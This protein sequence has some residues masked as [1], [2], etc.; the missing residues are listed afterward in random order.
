MGEPTHDT[1]ASLGSQSWDDDLVMR[2]D[3]V[4][5][6]YRAHQAPARDLRS[7]LTKPWTARQ[8]VTVDAVCGVS[9]DLLR[10]EALGIIGSNGSGK[11]TLLRTLAGLHTPQRGAVWG[12][13]Y[14]VLLGVASALK[15]RLTG[16]RNI[17]LGAL[18]LGMTRVELAEREPE[19]VE[20]ADLG[21]AIDR[22][23]RTYSSGMRARL[24]FAI[25]TSVQPDILL[26]DEALA[27][28]DRAF[29]Q[30]SYERLRQLR[31]KAS[32]LILV[33]HS[34]PEIRRAC[35]RVIWLDQGRVVSQGDPRQVT[36]QYEPS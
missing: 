35:D 22:P 6:S 5:V 12:K 25:A 7:Y 14:P 1:S 28:G 2:V 16:R 26:L 32:A 18:A 13:T 36:D 9:F 17:R 31:E 11:S 33:T 27:V 30:R 4:W 24:Q 23:M 29:K 10:G 34:M 3:N 19:I 21:P 15:P 8:F 20:F